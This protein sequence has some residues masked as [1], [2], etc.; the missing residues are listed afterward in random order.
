[1]KREGEL[2]FYLVWALNENEIT[3]RAYHSAMPVGYA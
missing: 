3:G 2:T 1:M